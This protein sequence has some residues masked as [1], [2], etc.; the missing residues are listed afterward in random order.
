MSTMITGGLSGEA[1]GDNEPEGDWARRVFDPG[2]WLV[3]HRVSLDRAEAAWLEVL[4]EFDIEHGWAVDGM[5]S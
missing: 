3:E 5:L 1:D 4:A 2:G